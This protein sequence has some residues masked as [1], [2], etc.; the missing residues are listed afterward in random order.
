[1]RKGAVVMAASV[2]LGL[3]AGAGIMSERAPPFAV[4]QNG[5]EARGALARAKSFA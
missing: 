4:T 2:L 1:M 5:L 3:F